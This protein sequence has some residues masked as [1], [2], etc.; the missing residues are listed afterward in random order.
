MK[1]DS[2][3]VSFLLPSIEKC[4]SFLAGISHFLQIPLPSCTGR[5]FLSPLARVYD[6]WVSIS[7]LREGWNF[8]ESKKKKIKKRTPKP[9]LLYL[10]LFCDMDTAVLGFPRTGNP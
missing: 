4:S 6:C 3:A 9:H 8:E 1:E 7:D 2:A 10:K 5:R